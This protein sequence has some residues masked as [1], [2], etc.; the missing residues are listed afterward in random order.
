MNLAQA[1]V[2]ISFALKS[3]YEVFR[4]KNRLSMIDID[5]GANWH[6]NALS[7]FPTWRVSWIERSGELYAVAQDHSQYLVLGIF[8]EKEEVDALLAEW[9]D[10]HSPDY[11]NLSALWMG[12]TNH[13]Y[14]QTE[15]VKKAKR[16]NKGV[17]NFTRTLS[18]NEE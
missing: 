11:R 9:L 12:I 15:Q 5:Y 10:P 1:Q 4:Q 6:L 14:E 18:G 2:A 8:H 13:L 7:L 17:R 3:N 16:F